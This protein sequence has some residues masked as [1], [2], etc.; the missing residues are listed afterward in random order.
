MTAPRAYESKTVELFSF[1]ITDMLQ[2][3]SFWSNWIENS[4]FPSQLL[5]IPYCHRRSA[6]PL[7]VVNR[8]QTGGVID[9]I[10]VPF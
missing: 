7:A 5:G 9:Q 2:F 6:P 1:G 10:A 4:N 3:Q 8:Q